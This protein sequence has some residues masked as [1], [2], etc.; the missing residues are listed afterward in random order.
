MPFKLSGGCIPYIR[1]V[2]KTILACNV[3]TAAPEG[4]AVCCQEWLPIWRPTRRAGQEA[5]HTL[6]RLEVQPK[7]ELKD[8][9]ARLDGA[10][11][12]AVSAGHLA[13]GRAGVGIG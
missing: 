3:K 4:A 7:H 9:A 6:R 8:P 1:C 13:E 2:V 5:H 12:V 11:D 10:G